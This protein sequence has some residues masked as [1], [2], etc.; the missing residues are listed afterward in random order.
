MSVFGILSAILFCTYGLTAY[1]A[2]PRIGTHQLPYFPGYNDAANAVH[3]L[4]ELALLGEPSTYQ[5]NGGFP[6]DQRQFVDLVTLG[7]RGAAGDGGPAAILEYPPLAPHEWIEMGVFTIFYI[8]YALISCILLLNL[9]IGACIPLAH[10]PASYP[11]PCSLPMSL[12]LTHPH[13]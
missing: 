12:L 13:R 1:V 3:E 11:C 8:T 7:V 2:Y 5:L 4:F 6:V 9:L 10:V